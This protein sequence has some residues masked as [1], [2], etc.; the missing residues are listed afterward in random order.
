M[1][2]ACRVTSHVVLA[3]YGRG[4]QVVGSILRAG[5]PAALESVRASSVRGTYY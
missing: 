5:L 2:A 4:A 3:C 1:N